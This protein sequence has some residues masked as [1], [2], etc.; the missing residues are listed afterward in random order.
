M[1]WGDVPAKW[2]QEKAANAYVTSLKFALNEIDAGRCPPG[3]LPIQFVAQ[4]LVT[5]FAMLLEETVNAES[6]KHVDCCVD[7]E[8]LVNLRKRLHEP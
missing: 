3:L 4:I 8:E 6:A 5:G 7:R 1:N 2:A